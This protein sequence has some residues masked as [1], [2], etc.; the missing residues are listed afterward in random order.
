MNKQQ[1]QRQERFWSSDP[2]L[3]SY[4]EVIARRIEHIARTAGQL[5]GKGKLADFASGHE[6]FGLHFKNDRWILREWAPYAT[7]VFLVGE[8]SDWQVR[9]DLALT[10]VDA[11]GTWEIELAAERLRH[12]DL[13]RLHVQWPGGS[14]DRI[15]AWTRR[16][17]QDPH[18]HIFNSQVWHPCKPYA[19]RAPQFKSSMGAPL[20]Y[21]VHI[22]MATEDGRV[23][24]YVEFTQQILPRVIAAG[25]NTLQIMAIPEHPYYG[26]FGYHVSSFFAASS[27]FGTPEELKELIDSAH[28]ADLRVLIDLVHSHAANNE[29]EGISRLDGSDYQFFHS[30]PRGHH[31]AWDS[32]LFDYG[33]PQVLHFLLSN[34]RYW[35]DE[36][37]VDG[38]RFDGITSMI[39]HD[40]GLGKAFTCYDDYFNGNVDEDALCY[41]A[42]ANQVIH[43]VRPDAITIAEDVSGMPGLARSWDDGGIGFDYR[44]AMGIP[45]YWIKLTKDMRDEAWPMNGLWFELNNRRRDERTISYTESHDQA[46]VGDKT[47]I[48]R[49]IDAD[50]YNHMAIGDECL[51]VVRGIAL[52]KMIRLITLATAGHGY[53]NFMGNEFGHPEWIDF[54]RPGNNWSHHY[55]RRQW[56]LVDN[57]HLRYRQL[58]LFDRDMITLVRKQGVLKSSD[59]HLILEHNDDKVLIFERTGLI[60]AFN[61]HPT[62]SYFDFQFPAAPG[63]YHIVLDSDDSRYG[64]FDRLDRGQSHF[65]FTADHARSHRLSLYL[66]NR[67]ALVVKC[68]E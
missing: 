48:F 16:V 62:R 31:A 56:H 39:Y 40:H 14:G 41:L 15:P 36:F 7:A 33:K 43:Q 3:Y 25:Y 11:D 54:P 28:A 18:S 58:A 35:L 1:C 24:S 45:D 27:R 46:L 66:P 12:K 34:C 60:W 61:F 21:E 20:I 47:L 22:G 32:R 30:G 50:M 57:P 23:G 5:A 59:P 49:M 53:L 51:P 9:G 55:A 19:W 8:L 42:L 29:V 26:S 37:R 2:Y 13:Y 65:T 17:V 38:F 64:G 63:R 67:T 52:H 6:F 4:R 44:F 68:V 10:R